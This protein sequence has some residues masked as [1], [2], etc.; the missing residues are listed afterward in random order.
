MKSTAFK[1]A[2]YPLYVFFILF[3]LIGFAQEPEFKYS[4][5]D[6]PLV[7]DDPDLIIWHVKA[8]RPNGKIY[9]IKAIDKDGEFHPVKAIQDS[10][11]TQL[12]DVK[13]FVD[14][15]KL[16][17]KLIVK[18]GD[19]YYPLKAIDSEGNIIDIKAITEKGEI[20][21]VKG[22]SKSG[23]V[24][25][26]RAIENDSI[27]YNVVAISPKG[28]MNMVKGLKMSKE[29]VETEING[30]KIFAHVKALTKQ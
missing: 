28:L 12:L 10:D 30:V 25:H 21:D 26:V 8:L 6:K 2:G 7:L 1:Y 18:N 27:F 9:H 19:R 3:S 5:I 20:L 11:Q 14:G 22:V 16:P 24:V 29:E 23:N 13:A 17:V 4:E 15:K